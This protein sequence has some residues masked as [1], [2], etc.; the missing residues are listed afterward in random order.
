MFIQCI[1][2]APNYF[3]C[4][5]GF[6][7]DIQELQCRD[8][9]LVDCGSRNYYYFNPKGPISIESYLLQQGLLKQ[10]ITPNVPK[11]ARQ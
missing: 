9:K 1:E 3:H 6:L 8:E 5:N 10:N 4:D 7:F 11:H 2:G